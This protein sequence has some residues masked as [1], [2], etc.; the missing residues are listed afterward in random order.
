M[1]PISV[2]PAATENIHLFDLETKPSFLC[3]KGQYM[4]SDSIFIIM[5]YWML[6]ESRL[7]VLGPPELGFRTPQ[8]NCHPYIILVLRSDT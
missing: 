5:Y 3:N 4:Y 1:P 2:G 8:K 7:A 6:C